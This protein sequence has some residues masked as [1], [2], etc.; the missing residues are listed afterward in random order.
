MRWILI[1]AAAGLLSACSKGD[2]TISA[3]IA[4]QFD[5]KSETVVDLSIVGPSG[6][7]RVCILT[8]YTSNAETEK[9]L[10]FKWDSDTKTSI[11][12]S[13]GI[14][15][16][17]FLRGR[18]VLTFTE[19]PRNKG[20]FSGVVSRCVSRERAKFIRVAEKDGWTYLRSAHDL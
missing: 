3:A 15:V 6:W 9:V 19:H 20:D 8:P 12:G 17:V 10:G 13:D 5:R 14:N 7:D 4:D 11:G 1:S 2:S 18:E 16:V